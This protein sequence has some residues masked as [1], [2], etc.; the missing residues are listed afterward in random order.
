MSSLLAAQDAGV[1]LRGEEAYAGNESMTGRVSRKVG[2]SP[3]PVS[4][5]YKYFVPGGCLM[6]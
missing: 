5:P 4:L 1:Q 6:R 3:V 2:A